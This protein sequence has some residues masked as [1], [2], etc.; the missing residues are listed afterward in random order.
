MPRTILCCAALCGSV[1][2]AAIKQAAVLA[3]AA[4]GSSVQQP[5]DLRLGIGALP[6]GDVQ[7]VCDLVLQVGGSAAKE[8]ARAP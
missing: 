5:V 8:S 3:A 7:P 4:A 1:L 6:P 2:E